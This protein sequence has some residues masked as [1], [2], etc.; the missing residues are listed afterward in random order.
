M[1]SHMY[2]QIP[3]Y[4]MGKRALL[5]FLHIN[6]KFCNIAIGRVGKIFEKKENN[7]SDA[8]MNFKQGRRLFHFTD[9]KTYILSVPLK[10]FI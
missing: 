8:A 3:L 4:T 2:F 1:H 9:A 7:N 6:A 5:K 10:Q